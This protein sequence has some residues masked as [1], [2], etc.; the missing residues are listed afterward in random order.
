M[1]WIKKEMRI[2]WRTQGPWFKNLGSPYHDRYMRGCVLTPQPTKTNWRVWGQEDKLGGG[3]GT[4]EG[5]DTGGLN[6]ART[7]D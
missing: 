2:M 6:G 5:G 4:G 3:E 1:K 7:D